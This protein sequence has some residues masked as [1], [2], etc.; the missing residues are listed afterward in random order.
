MLEI[1]DRPL[2]SVSFSGL[3]AFTYPDGSHAVGATCHISLINSDGS[4]NGP[5]ANVFFAVPVLRTVTIQEAERAALGRAHDVLV[6]LASF[7]VDDLERM[8]E[9]K[10]QADEA[11]GLTNFYAERK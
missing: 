3:E 1:K 7:S 6:R 8:F 5:S 10:R 2:S 11:S 4:E 9:H